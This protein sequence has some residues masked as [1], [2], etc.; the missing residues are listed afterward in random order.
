MFRMMFVIFH[1]LLDVKPQ[2]MLYLF[3]LFKGSYEYCCNFRKS[4]SPVVFHFYFSRISCS[5]LWTISIWNLSSCPNFPNSMSFAIIAIHW[6]HDFL[7]VPFNRTKD[8]I[9][10]D[11]LMNIL[12]IQLPQPL[13]DQK[14]DHQT[15]CGVC[16]A[17]YLPIG[18]ATFL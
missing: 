10:S 3:P 5:G 2:L 6:W 12:D 14:N 4:S 7:C 8:N 13:N 18:N 15:E 9:F 11:N 1:L 16:Y 17:Q